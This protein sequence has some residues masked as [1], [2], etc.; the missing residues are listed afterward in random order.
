MTEMAEIQRELCLDSIN[1]AL[2]AGSTLLQIPA[3]WRRRRCVRC[4][5]SRPRAP[6]PLAA[7][8]PEAPAGD[9]SRY[10]VWEEMP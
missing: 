2:E 7:C 9:S 1:Y 10:P 3:G 8:R 5:A 4:K 6:D